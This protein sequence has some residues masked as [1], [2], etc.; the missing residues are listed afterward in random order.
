[1]EQGKAPFG[2]GEG[3]GL[4]RLKPHRRHY[5]AG[6]ACQRPMPPLPRSLLS[7][8]HTVA[9]H[10][11]RRRP[12]PCLHS[13]ESRPTPPRS[14]LFPPL[15]SSAHGQA[16]T[17]LIHAGQPSRCG[18][19]RVFDRCRRPPPLETHQSAAIYLF[20]TALTSLVLPHSSGS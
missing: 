13:K 11:T 5:A 20:G 17:H 12:A 9:G 8:S 14:L 15:L 2:A 6:P 1:L 7:L 10:W 19:Q 4:N 16:C 3:T 18:P